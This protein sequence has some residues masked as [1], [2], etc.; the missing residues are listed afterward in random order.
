MAR[1]PSS[2][3]GTLVVKQRKGPSVAAVDVRT[4][5]MSRLCRD[6]RTSKQRRRFRILGMNTRPSRA[7]GGAM[8]RAI[9]YSSRTPADEHFKALAV[10]QSPT[11]RTPVLVGARQEGDQQ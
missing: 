2:Y 11:G 7:F 3:R 6:V 10:G 4:A 8:P 5:V 1:L 9:V